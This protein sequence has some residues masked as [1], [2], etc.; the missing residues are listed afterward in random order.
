MSCEYTPKENINNTATICMVTDGIVYCSDHFMMYKNIIGCTLI[1]YCMLII[2][3]QKRK[4]RHNSF[5]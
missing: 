2:I 5:Q 3:Q 4:K 1:Q